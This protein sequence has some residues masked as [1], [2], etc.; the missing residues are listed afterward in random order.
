MSLPSDVLTTRSMNRHYRALSSLGMSL[1][2]AVL[3][4]RPMNCYYRALFSLPDQW[5]V[6]IYYRG[7]VLTTRSINCHYRALSSLPDQWIVSTER[8]SHCQINGSSLV[9]TTERCSHYQIILST[10]P[11]SLSGYEINELS[12][13]ERCGGHFDPRSHYKI[14]ELLLASAVLTTRSMNC[15]SRAP[16][17]L[18]THPN[19][20]WKSH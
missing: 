16:S 19:D 15:H 17:S 5:I 1:P 9:V 13:F 7:A 8:C 3:I 20:S 18:P 11:M 14:N 10:T 6:T 12:L 2:S 4:T